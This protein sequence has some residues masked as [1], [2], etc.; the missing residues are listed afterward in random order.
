MSPTSR[1]PVT[2]SLSKGHG[3]GCRALGEGCPGLVCS[4]PDTVPSGMTADS[5]QVR[6]GDLFAAL[7]GS[8]TDGR[9]FMDQALAQGA[10]AILDDGTWSPEPA[11]AERVCRLVHPEPRQAWA[12]LAAAFFGHPARALRTV[13]I[14]GT[15]GKT[16][17]A[18]MVES[19]LTVAGERVGVLGTTGN[20]W[21]GMQQAATMTTPDPVTLQS[22]LWDMQTAGCT[23]SVMEVS[24][25]ALDQ[26]RVA[27]ICFDVGVFLNLTRDHLDYHGSEE[28]YFAA[29]LR[30]FQN[31]QT[32]HAVINRDDPHGAGVAGQCRMDGI[33]FV[34]FAADSATRTILTTEKVGQDECPFRA[35]SITTG[36]QGTRFR[37]D[38]PAGELEINLPVAGYFNVANALAAAAAA[39]QLALPLPVIREGLARFIPPPGRMQ[40]IDQ[41]QPFA[42]VVD[43]AHTPDALERLLVTA[44]QMTPG[45]LIV[46]FGC[47]GERDKTKRAMMGRIS[48]QRADVTIVTDDNPRSEQPATI[49]RAI[50]DGV[51]GAVADHEHFGHDHLVGHQ[52]GLFK[53][54]V[55]GAGSLA[56]PGQSPGGVWGEAPIDGRFPNSRKDDQGQ[57]LCLEI[58]DRDQAIA[59]AITLA[60]AGDAVLL[61]G[62]GHETSQIVAGQVLP[63]DDAEVARR[64]LRH[65]MDVLS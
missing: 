19:I 47:G 51:A 11:V 37:M 52:R 53:N 24:S 17:V 46:L 1:K 7:P 56:G 28:A 54:G 18:A 39:W 48:A 15:N 13:G 58:G 22:L 62:K 26:Q 31:G 3:L 25:H 10:V 4:G 59:R 61:A 8:R 49:R 45:R 2:H 23:A 6:P 5:R 57:H 29:K 32:K 35:D 64:H 63:F 60:K 40:V 38:T 14:T 34:T 55:Q 43:F 16:T 41:G 33:P 42:V 44:R 65:R 36:W 12:R 21:P 30:L 20:R 27:G 9:L 50:L